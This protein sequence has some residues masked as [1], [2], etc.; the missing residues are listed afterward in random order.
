[1]A[2]IASGCGLVLRGIRLPQ[3]LKAA[4]NLR[5]GRSGCVAVGRGWQE[6]LNQAAGDIEKWTYQHACL[7]CSPGANQRVHG[8]GNLQIGGRQFFA[9]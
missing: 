9:G 1:M 8:R 3:L 5:E 6:R 7:L 4:E 2:I